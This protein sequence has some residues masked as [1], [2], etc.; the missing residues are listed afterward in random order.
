MGGT[1]SKQE[2]QIITVA[3][4]R[5]IRQKFTYVPFKGG[6]TVVVNLVG[7]HINSSVNNPIAG[8]AQWR[9]G[10]LR[11]LCVCDEKRMPYQGK[12]YGDTAWSRVPTERMSIVEGKS[13]SDSE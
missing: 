4:E 1:G 8:V 11:P 6:G 5:L 12:M 2:V 13:E 7:K 3:L 9:A 10:A